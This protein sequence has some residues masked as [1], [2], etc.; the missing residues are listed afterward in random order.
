MVQLSKRT[1][2]YT[3]G[4]CGE[5]GEIINLFELHA[6]QFSRDCKALLRCCCSAEMTTDTSREATLDRLVSQYL[7]KR[8]CGPPLQ[9][10]LSYSRKES[11]DRSF[12]R[13]EAA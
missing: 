1:S 5:Y 6:L 8:K 7:K 12:Y 2:Q 9:L 3:T 11:T 10:V 13:D 4:N